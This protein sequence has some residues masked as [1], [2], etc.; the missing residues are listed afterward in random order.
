[1]L[2]VTDTNKNDVIASLYIEAANALQQADNNV[3]EEG[4]VGKIALS[5]VGFI[6]LSLLLFAPIIEKVKRYKLL[7]RLQKV[8]LQPV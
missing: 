6:T 5:A 8:Y 1:M 4:I 3:L 2:K 7:K